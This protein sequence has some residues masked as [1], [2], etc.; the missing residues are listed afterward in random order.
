VTWNL[1]ANWWFYRDLFQG[2][3]PVPASPLTLGWTP[4]EPATWAEVPC[5]T[6]GSEVV[7]EAPT[8]GLYE[9]ALRYQGPGRGA[10]AFTMVQNDINVAVDADGY[11]AL[12]PGAHEQR[13]PVAVRDPGSGTTVLA[14]RDV[15]GDDGALTTLE[16]CTASSITYP[17]GADTAALYGRLLAP[18]PPAEGG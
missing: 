14:T 8:A 17:E 11:V 7:V 4:A 2:Y 1:S 6:E 13:F 10:R 16:S 12:D 15:P 9:V 3:A 5:R 18:P